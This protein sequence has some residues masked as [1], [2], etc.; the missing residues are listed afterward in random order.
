MKKWLRR[1]RAIAVALLVCLCSTQVYADSMEDAQ[2]DKE[3][4]EENKKSAE[5]ILKELEATKNNL[6]LYVQELDAELSVIQAD[7][8]DLN[9]QKAELEV[10]IEKKQ[11]ELELAKIDEQNQYDDMCARIQFMY[12]NGMT[13]YAD[14]LLTADSMCE[15]LNQPEYVSAVAQ[16]DYEMLDKLAATR[17]K[18]ANDEVMLQMDLD[19]VEQLK[20]E[21]EDR[22]NDLN[23]LIQDKADSISEY[24]DQI[25]RQQK[26]V[27]E[28]DREL[29][30]AA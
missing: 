1:V 19:S 12:E 8:E 23:V 11:Q 21:A 14:A 25:A 28:Y 20:A 6:E 26:V 18:I 7:I 29:Q 9:R 3:E 27:D 16:Y 22:E 13:N 24:E 4:A 15:F 2:K 10:D 5:D 30:A 17:E